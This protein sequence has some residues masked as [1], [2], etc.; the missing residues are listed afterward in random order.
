MIGADV[1]QRLEET[2]REVFQDPELELRP[3]WTAA[4]VEAWDSLSHVRLMVA[5]EQAFRIRFATAEIAT[6]PNVGAL[7]ELVQRRLQ[8]SG[9]S[10][11]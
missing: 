11:Q 6:L 4:D 5:V 2:F 8:E 1:W 7:A 9:G 10:R 3:E